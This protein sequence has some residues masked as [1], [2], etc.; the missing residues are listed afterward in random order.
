MPSRAFGDTR[1]KWPTRTL[2]VVLPH[3][4]GPRRGIPR[5]YK[6]PPYVVACP[7]VVHYQR[8]QADKFM[9]LATDGLWDELDSTAACQV[10]GTTKEHAATALLKCAFGKDANHLL[11]IPAPQSRKYRDDVTINVIKF[12]TDAGIA[13]LKEAGK[14]PKANPE[15]LSKW[16]LYLK[17]YSSK[18]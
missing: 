11:S 12:D 9:I 4:Y 15:S 3:I 10:V 18:L 5:N 16:A 14:R 7:E 2:E 13:D 1:Y 8:D 17:S 6:T